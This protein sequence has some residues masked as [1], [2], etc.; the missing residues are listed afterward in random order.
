[1]KAQLKSFRGDFTHWHWASSQHGSLAGVRLLTW[2][3]RAPSTKFHRTREK[4][5]A[6]CC[7][8]LFL[9]TTTHGYTCLWLQASHKSI[10][11]Q[12]KEASCFRRAF[13]P[14]SQ[15]LSFGLSP[16]LC[17]RRAWLSV[18]WILLWLTLSRVL[19]LLNHLQHHYLT[20]L[21]HLTLCY[22]LSRNSPIPWL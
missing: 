13:C 16:N 22:T 17:F 14:C 11:I 12:G 9:I 4:L 3:L 21:C 5:P 6:F 2:E 10:Q 18:P 20:H 1:M 19:L 15:Y 8:G 7:P